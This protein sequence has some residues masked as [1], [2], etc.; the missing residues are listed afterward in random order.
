[1]TEIIKIV[2]KARRR[3]NKIA[4]DKNVAQEFPLA[5]FTEKQ[6]EAFKNDPVLKVTITTDKKASDDGPDDETKAAQIAE[7]IKQRDDERTE[8]KAMLLD[9]PDDLQ[10]KDGSPSSTKLAKKLGFTVTSETLAVVVAEIEK[11]AAE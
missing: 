3:R 9:L 11:E 6:I 8:L 7:M 4:F 2:A 1:M 5:E 10:N